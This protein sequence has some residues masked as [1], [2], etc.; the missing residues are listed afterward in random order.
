MKPDLAAARTVTRE[1]C[2]WKF[3]PDGRA[4]TAPM[5]WLLVIVLLG[6][7]AS[8]CRRSVDSTPAGSRVELRMDA[9]PLLVRADTMGT[10]TSQI[11]A[12]VLEDGAPI[13]DST[14]VYF[15]TSLGSITSDAYT[16][17]GLARAIFTSS[18]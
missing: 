3:T 5:A 6:S 15:A 13:A 8:S 18:K 2:A 16:K 4:W 14:V 12:T 7:M 10:Q 11:W 17:D 9:M 1:G